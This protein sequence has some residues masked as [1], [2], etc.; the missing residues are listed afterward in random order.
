V[1]ADLT[2]LLSQR[3]NDRL[4]DYRLLTESMG[5]VVEEEAPRS[6]PQSGVSGRGVGPRDAWAGADEAA[7]VRLLEG[8]RVAL[9]AEDLAAVEALHV[10]L[11]PAMR[12]AL[13]KYFQNAER[14]QVAF[15]KLD[16]LVAGDEAL[17][18]FTRADDFVDTSTGLPVHLEMRVSSVVTRDAGAWRLRGLKK[19]GSG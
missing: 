9:E 14:L 15:T 18:T 12:E 7:I 1:D 10:A 19:P 4:E 5:G 2:R 17:A 3:T 16:I 13:R 11:T 8:Y 6:E